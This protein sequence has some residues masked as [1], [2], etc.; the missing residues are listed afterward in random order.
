MCMWVRLARALLWSPPLGQSN[1]ARASGLSVGTNQAPWALVLNGQYRWCIFL[2]KHLT[3]AS[4]AIYYRS[5]DT[6]AVLRSPS[7]SLSSLRAVTI[8]SIFFVCFS[9][10]ILSF[11][12]HRIQPLSSVS[13]NNVS[14]SGSFLVRLGDVGD[15]LIPIFFCLRV[16]CIESCDDFAHAPLEIVLDFHFNRGLAPSPSLSLLEFE[17]ALLQLSDN[18]RLIRPGVLPPCVTQVGKESARSQHF[19]TP[20]RT[21]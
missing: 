17:K 4:L 15:R 16:H 19:E 7:P 10:P 13:D 1:F 11:G 8:E 6:G 2:A 9:Q 5:V 12:L 18:V 21:R 3:G 14:M 20:K